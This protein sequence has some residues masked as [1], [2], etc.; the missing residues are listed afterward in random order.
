MKDGSGA[1]RTRDEKDGLDDLERR[2]RGGMSRSG[3]AVNWGI[4]A[5]VLGYSVIPSFGARWV[6]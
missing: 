1:S 3:D 6:W 2:V 4:T 5:P